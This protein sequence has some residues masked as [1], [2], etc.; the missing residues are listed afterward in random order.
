MQWIGKIIILLIWSVH[1]WQVVDDEVQ[2]TTAAT[3]AAHKT[4]E[5]EGAT[6]DRPITTTPETETKKSSS[7]RSDDDDEDS[8]DDQAPSA[9][10]TA[11]AHTEHH[12]HH[13]EGATT[14]AVTTTAKAPEKAAD[15]VSPLTVLTELKAI[16][17]KQ[18]EE[19]PH[20]WAVALPA[21]L[22]GLTMVISGRIALDL[23]LIVIGA[24]LG[25][26]LMISEMEYQL[27]TQHVILQQIL[28]F[29]TACVVAL[30]TQK[31]L[32][33]AKYL[34]GALLGAFCTAQLYHIGA[35]VDWLQQWLCTPVGV[36][37]M[38]NIFVLAGLCIVWREWYLQ[39]LGIIYPLLG[40]LLVASSLLFFASEAVWHAASDP[41]QAAWKSMH[42]RLDKI[43]GPWI[44]FLEMLLHPASGRD[45]GIF[46]GYHDIE[47][48][49]KPRDLL[50]RCIGW[51][52]WFICM[53]IGI[54]TQL[55]RARPAKNQVGPLGPLSRPLL[56]N[57][58]YNLRP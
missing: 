55:G 35:E 46:A 44:V 16:V 47:L 21:L 57:N 58:N 15:G 2:A 37:A 36:T 13:T 24:L 20:Q 40:G 28:A 6:T 17:R 27:G 30:V 14:E 48:D 54:H 26:V 19:G 43:R 1:G 38:L 11:A 25:Y 31:G 33:G 7:T 53:A 22:A 50:D 45:A 3:D 39:V 9:S 32:P 5:G 49:G 8:A 42:M 18:L 10:T 29:E 51:F 34:A 52:F 23:M 41:K 12:T 4:H 56:E